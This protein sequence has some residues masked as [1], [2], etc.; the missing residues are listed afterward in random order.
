MGKS[1]RG[2]NLD[3]RRPNQHSRA[4]AAGPNR[5]SYIRLQ[6]LRA[7]LLG[8]SRPQ[9]CLRCARSDRMVRLWLE[10]F[11]RGGIDALRAKNSGH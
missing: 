5:R 9:V 11:N 3:Y 2:S 7:L 8:F 4:L 1:A 10:L 6:A